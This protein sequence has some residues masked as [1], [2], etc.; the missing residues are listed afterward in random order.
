MPGPHTLQL[1]CVAA[2]ASARTRIP[3]LSILHKI[4]GRK[5]TTHSNSDVL[6]DLIPRITVCGLG[7]AGGN[8]VNNMIRRQFTGV[9]FLVANTDAQALSLSTSKKRVQLGR[10]TTRGL[11]AGARPS[12]GQSAAK[13]TL[14]EVLNEIGNSHMVFVTAGMG[15]GTGTGAAP[16]IAN[17]TKAKGI[18]T[19]GIVTKPFNFEGKTRMRIAEEG[20]AELEKAVDTLIVIPNQRLLGLDEKNFPL[21]ESFKLVDDVLYNGIKGVTDVL[22]KPGLI[23]LDFADVR[24]IMTDMGRSLMGTGEAEGRARAKTAAEKALHNPLL[25][26]VSISGAKG[27]LIN[28]ASAGDSTLY[29]VDEIVNTVSEAVDADA[30]IIFGSSV[31]PD[32]QGKLRVT[33]IVTGMYRGEAKNQQQHKQPQQQHHQNQ[34]RQQSQGSWSGSN[35]HQPT[36]PRQAYAPPQSQQPPQQQLPQQ[37]SPP[38]QEQKK[39]GIFEKAKTFW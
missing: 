32:L 36:P 25:E 33:L 10:D 39:M 29:E 18:L 34:Q 14:D 7:G 12:V 15:G 23:N 26:D 17:A 21:H 11:G 31:D 30:N 16:V 37:Q 27:V 1:L 24:T 5:Y 9:D 8:T 22:V 38:Q 20:L 6:V 4:S 2:N 19:V 13:E 28:V 3:Q 35:K